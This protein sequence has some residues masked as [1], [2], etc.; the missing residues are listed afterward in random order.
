MAPVG[1]GSPKSPRPSTASRRS[2]PTAMWISTTPPSAPR[3]LCGSWSPM[4]L[5]C[6]G[7]DNFPTRYLVNDACVLLNKPNVY[8][9]IFRFE[10][11]ATVFNFEDGPNYRDLYPEPPPPAWCPP[12][13]RGVWWVSCQDS[14]A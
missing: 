5:I 8:G 12:V 10:G 6:D 7:T 9:S 13:P 4:T 11:Q 2:I 3:T 14:S 1:W